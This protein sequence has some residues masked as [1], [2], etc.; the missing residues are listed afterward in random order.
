LKAFTDAFG[1]LTNSFNVAFAAT[2]LKAVKVQYNENSQH[3][4]LELR[5]AQIPPKINESTCN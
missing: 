5:N 4:S 1:I 3:C 2:S